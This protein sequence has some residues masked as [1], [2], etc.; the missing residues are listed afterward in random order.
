MTE[1]E[2]PYLYSI[3]AAP[4]DLVADAMFASMERCQMGADKLSPI[5][6]LLADQNNYEQYIERGFQKIYRLIDSDAVSPAAGTHLDSGVVIDFAPAD[7]SRNMNMKRGLIY[8]QVVSMCFTDQFGLPEN[9]VSQG[10]HEFCAWLRLGCPDRREALHR[11]VSAV[12][13]LV[14]SDIVVQ[15]RATYKATEH[16]IDRCLQQYTHVAT[17]LP[18]YYIYA[19]QNLPL[20]VHLLRNR[21]YRNFAVIYPSAANTYV[22]SHGPLFEPGY[23]D[24]AGDTNDK[25]DSAGGSTDEP[26]SD[27]GDSV[28]S[29]KS[30]KSAES[31]GADE[32]STDGTVRA[33]REYPQDVLFTPESSLAE[34]APDVPARVMPDMFICKKKKIPP[35]AI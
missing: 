9:S 24:R 21:G 3:V 10:C 22:F 1:Y 11:V 20:V 34:L 7:W 8:F 16:M 13:I 17:E 27:S 4:G 6:Y 26:G 23:S 30:N 32:P 33:A 15:W 29:D 31:D 12:D 2:T 35:Y 28:E 18:Y 25:S 5:V 19:T 14:I